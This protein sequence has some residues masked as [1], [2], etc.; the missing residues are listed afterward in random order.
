LKT[1]N[2]I[3]RDASH[4]PLTD[5]YAPNWGPV[6]PAKVGQTL[7]KLRMCPSFANDSFIRFAGEEAAHLAR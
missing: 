5:N 6:A 4:R 3:K 2:D 1:R 7:T